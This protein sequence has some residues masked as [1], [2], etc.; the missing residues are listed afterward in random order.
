MRT[1]T[2]FCALICLGASACDLNLPDVDASDDSGAG[3]EDTDGRAEAPPRPQGDATVEPLSPAP[4]DDD[5]PFGFPCINDGR[6]GAPGHTCCQGG[7]VLICDDQTGHYTFLESCETSFGETCD[8]QRG[9]CV[10]A[11]NAVRCLP[12][13]RF[14]ECV[15]RQGT[16]NEFGD[17][18]ACPPGTVCV[19]D[20]NGGCREQFDECREGTLSCAPGQPS[21]VF[22][23]RRLTDGF[24]HLVPVLD[25]PEAGMVACQ[26]PSLNPA[27]TTGPRPGDP[28][29]EDDSA[30]VALQFCVNA[31]DVQ[32]VPL[33]ARPC[34]R[35]PEIGC[36][37]WRC[38]GA[39]AGAPEDILAPDHTGC[40]PEGA[41]CHAGTEC[42]SCLCQGL[43]C[44]GAGTEFCGDPDECR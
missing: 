31:C 35:H 40:L 33:P 28:V 16:F 22:H 9:A 10:C 14:Q 24:T 39:V 44:V 32:G 2:L 20:F 34:E 7:N 3:S 26:T 18:H 6:C 43:R 29:S 25:C 41:V 17:P 21:L 15:P 8:R 42:A 38:T 37:L 27:L 11:P 13:G 19:E 5:S 4:P 30:A 36:A 23:C 1:H 12:D